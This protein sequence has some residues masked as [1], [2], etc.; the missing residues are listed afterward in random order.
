MRQVALAA[1]RIDQQKKD[2]VKHKEQ[3][4]GEVRDQ[5]LIESKVEETHHVPTMKESFDIDTLATKPS[6]EIASEDVNTERSS[7]QK[8]S[9]PH[10]AIK[11][12]T[13]MNDYRICK[14]S[15]SITWKDGKTTTYSA[16]KYNQM[17]LGHCE[18]IQD[19][20]RQVNEQRRVTPE[21][22]KNQIQEMGDYIM[23]KQLKHS[24]GRIK[25]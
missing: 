5:N 8:Q 6:P 11:K 13:L 20:N 10:R 9:E 12:I 18:D 23:D 4:G 15:V 1:K 24:H 21:R 3:Q 2:D 22:L 17:W 25:H 16:D 19:Y 7:V 14:V